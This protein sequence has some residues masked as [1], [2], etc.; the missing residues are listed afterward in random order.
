MAG[1]MGW[2]QYIGD[3]GI[4]YK[5]RMDADSAA[6]VGAEAEPV[7]ATHD[8]FPANWS[9]RY[10]IAEYT[11]DPLGTGVGTRLD[12]RRVICPDPTETEWTGA[13][14]A[15]DLKNYYMPAATD[16]AGGATVSYAVRGRFGEKR[17]DN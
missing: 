14:N 13:D 5:I 15:I 16:E 1:A 6:A 17:P 3:T 2:F 9:P 12:R 4:T 11:S 7:P 10:L 8:R